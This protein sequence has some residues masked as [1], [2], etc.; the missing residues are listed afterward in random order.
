MNRAKKCELKT[1]TVDNGNARLTCPTTEETG[2]GTGFTAS[3]KGGFAEHWKKWDGRAVSRVQKLAGNTACGGCRYFGKSPAEVDELKG[4]EAAAKATRIFGEN[5]LLEA[6]AERDQ[7]LDRLGLTALTNTDEPQALEAG[8]AD[9]AP[10][11]PPED[12]PPVS[13][14]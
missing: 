14:R 8:S 11:T 7:L 4:Q 2:D 10:I 13:E 12:Q 5:Q 6:Q 3:G 1:I 9:N